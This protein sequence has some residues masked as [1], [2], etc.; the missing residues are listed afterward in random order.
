MKLKVTL[1]AVP[2][3]ALAFVAAAFAKTDGGAAVQTKSAA[4]IA[5]G[6]TRTIGVAAPITG[7]AAS[8]GQQQ[9]RWAQFYVK[10]WNAVKANAKQKIAIVQGDTQL[11]VDTAF[12]VKVA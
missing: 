1:L 12:A 11:G 6:K 4:A 9:L 2:I 8:I 5:C 10:R 7:P 3:L